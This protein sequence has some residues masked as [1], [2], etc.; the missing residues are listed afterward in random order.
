L[1]QATDTEHARI[2]RELHDDICQRMS[3]LTIELQS[4]VRAVPEGAS[5]AEALK[6]AQDVAIS[7]HELSHRLHPTQLRLIGA[8]AAIDRLCVEVS[9]AGIA[10][11]FTHDQVPASLPPDVML[12]LF[13]VAQESLQNAVKYSNARNVSVHLTGDTDR[14][15][16]TIVDDG[17]GFEVD[18]AW[19]KGVGLV[20]MVERLEAIGGTL[21][22]G[23]IAGEGTR[24]TATVPLCVVHNTESH[25]PL[26]P[27]SHTH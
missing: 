21:D 7:L 14:L 23:S 27:H 1:I 8:V 20:S 13:R 15:G 9:R 2:A 11:A 24:V 18:A 3:L 25:A 17:V 16:L 19:G 10:V 22:I 26:A 12:C 4:L 5:V 6:V